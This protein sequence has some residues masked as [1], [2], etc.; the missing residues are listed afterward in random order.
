MINEVH[1]IKILNKSVY[2]KVIYFTAKWCG[3]CKQIGPY[4]EQ[5]SKENPKVYFFKVDV[6]EFENLGVASIPTFHIYKD[7]LTPRIDIKGADREKIKKAVK[8]I[9]SM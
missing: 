6:D 2:P 1:D 7:I 8:D 9:Q 3:P 4:L 5:L